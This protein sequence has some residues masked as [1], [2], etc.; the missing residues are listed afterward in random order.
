MKKIFS[1]ED[2]IKMTA[3]SEHPEDTYYDEDKYSDSDPLSDDSLNRIGH[4]DLDSFKEAL[5]SELGKEPN[6]FG[7]TLPVYIFNHPKALRVGFLCHSEGKY[8]WHTVRFGQVKNDVYAV[9]MGNK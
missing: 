7:D 5:E 6:I 2:L 1:Y 8:A 3:A 4:K 9:Q